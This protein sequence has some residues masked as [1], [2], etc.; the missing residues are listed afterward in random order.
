MNEVELD[1]LADLIYEYCGIDFKRNLNSLQSKVAKRINEL[2]LSVR[3]YCGYLNSE[4]NEWKTLIELITINETYFFRE[5]SLLNE[6]R[7]VILPRFKECTIY[8]PLKI[9]CAAC[10][11]GEEPY[12]LAMIIK[13]TGLFKPGSVQIIGSD[14]N[15][16]VLKKAQEGIY[17]KKSFSFR[18]MPE[19]ML[20]KYF[21]EEAENYKVKDCIREMVE[22]REMNLLDKDISSKVQNIDIVLCRNVLIYFDINA[23][24]KIIDSIYKIL[25]PQR[26]LFLGHAETITNISNNFENICAPTIFYYKKGD[27]SL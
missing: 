15:R 8:N 7:D 22:F 13:E 4:P 3:E 23:I 1:R 12:T 9:W 21:H 24:K 19:L 11:S 17:S 16:K 6:F 14:I 18:K 20:S 5:E 26:Y 27:N 25:K 2:G 10:S